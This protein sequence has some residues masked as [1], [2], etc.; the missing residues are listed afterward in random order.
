MDIPRE[1]REQLNALSK[2][3][4]GTSS[5]WQK[6]LTRGYLETLTE[7]KEEEVP[8]ENGAAPTK[9]TIKVPK[10]RNGMEVRETRFHTVESILALMTD[11]KQKRDEMHAAMKKAQEEHEASQ[12]A[13][14]AAGGSATL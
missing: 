2:E 7:E 1:Q 4:M 3:L 13:Q 5:R 9:T 12:K 11:M 6:L 14:E 10:L 8:G